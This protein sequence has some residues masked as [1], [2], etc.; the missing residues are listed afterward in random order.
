MLH[1]EHF[2]S[3]ESISR[4][5][6]ESEAGLNTGCGMRQR[7]QFFPGTVNSKQGMRISTR[8]PSGVTPR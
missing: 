7:R 5:S 4:H 8:S 3:S 6:I 2:G 1:T